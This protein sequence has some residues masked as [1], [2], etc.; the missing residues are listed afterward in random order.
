VGKTGSVRRRA[1]P[2]A[3]YSRVAFPAELRSFLGSV[4][5]SDHTGLS[6]IF[7]PV[8]LALDVDVVEL[9]KS[10]SRMAEAITLSAKIDPKSP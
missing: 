4:F 3:A 6:L 7:E 9:C 5:G 2:G 8:A 10:R 1:K